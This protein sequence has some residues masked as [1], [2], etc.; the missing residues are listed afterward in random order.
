MQTV[1]LALNKGAECQPEGLALGAERHTL[2]RHWLVLGAEHLGAGTCN[3]TGGP[4]PP[5]LRRG[6]SPSRGWLGGFSAPASRRSAHRAPS[7][8]GGARPR[9]NP[10][11]SPVRLRTY[12]S[13]QYSKD[14]WVMCLANRPALPSVGRAVRPSSVPIPVLIA[15]HSPTQPG[16]CA[17]EAKDA[18]HAL[19][20]DLCFTQCLYSSSACTAVHT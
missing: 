15:H 5:R 16:V 2:A 20:P 10:R 14:R 13:D 11:R 6:A 4:L 8:S 19:Y 12:G 3:W 17:T 9:V 1:Q 7:A 18:S